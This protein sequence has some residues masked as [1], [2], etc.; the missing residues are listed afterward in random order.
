MRASGIAVLAVG[1][2]VGWVSLLSAQVLNPTQS[3]STATTIATPPVPIENQ[4]H[5]TN[6]PL[7]NNY[8]EPVVIP[9]DP[10]TGVW[11]PYWFAQTLEPWDKE[12]KQWSGGV[13]LGL[14][15]ANGNSEIFKVRFAGDGKRETE[16]TVLSFDWLYNYATANGEESENRAILNGKQELLFADSPWSWFFTE[17]V[18]YDEFKAYDIRLAL[19]TGLGYQWLKTKRTSLKTRV[20]AGGSWEFGGPN[21]DFMP[22]AVLGLDFEHKLTKRQKIT[23]VLDFFPDLAD[24]GEYRAQAKIDWE[25]LIDP[26]WN[27]TLKLGVLD[28][29]DSTPEGA[30]P[31][32]VQYYATILW[33]F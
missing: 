11:M 18:I 17:Q 26:D 9:E 32:D 10:E 27:L 21:N 13:E 16:A 31:N 4:P 20:G 8:L 6:Q 5:G 24:F 2:L 23:A 22:E 1:I 19:H 28:I 14:N 12:L 30:N 3:P 15:G 7:P 29:Y 33:R 25:M